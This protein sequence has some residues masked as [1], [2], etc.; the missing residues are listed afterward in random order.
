MVEKLTPSV[1]TVC[2]CVPNSVPLQKL[3]KVLTEIMCDHNLSFAGH[4]T[5]QTGAG[6]NCGFPEAG[7]SMI[8]DSPAQ[9]CIRLIFAT[10]TAVGFL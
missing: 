9:E 10:V 2:L 3:K 6:R 4:I 7:R 1:F 8:R 5:Q